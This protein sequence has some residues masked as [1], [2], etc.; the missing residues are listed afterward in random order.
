MHNE[1][2]GR[3]TLMVEESYQ[4]TMERERALLTDDLLPNLTDTLDDGYEVF[5]LSDEVAEAHDD[6]DWTDEP[7]VPVLE[8]QQGVALWP[9]YFV[10]EEDATAQEVLDGD[11][12]VAIE[13]EHKG[14]K[15]QDDDLYD[16]VVAFAEDWEDETNIE[17]RNSLLGEMDVSEVTLY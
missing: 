11:Y 5:N 8:T 7:D 10:A 2:W 13:P 15:I 16:D 9:E 14:V 3:C 17:T 4:K 6:Y 1:G 12:A